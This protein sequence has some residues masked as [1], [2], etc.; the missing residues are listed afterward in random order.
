LLDA[1][2]GKWYGVI[3][4]RIGGGQPRTLSQTEPQYGSQEECLADLK[5][6]MEISERQTLG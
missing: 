6:M 1:T 2:T 4:C 3:S 5:R